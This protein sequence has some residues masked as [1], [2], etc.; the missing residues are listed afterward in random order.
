MALAATVDIQ[1][2]DA[3]TVRVLALTR[4]GALGASSRI[5]F[6]QYLP[7]LAAAGVQVEVQALFNDDM[8]TARY[9]RGGYGLGVALHCF[10]RRITALCTRGKFDLLWIEKEALPWWPLWAEL[11][12]LR[13]V[14]YALDYDD[15]VFHNYDQHRLTVVRHVLGQRL[16]GLMSRA[17][18]VV[19]G[20]DYLAQRARD[21]GAGWVEVLPTVI[22]LV[23]YPAPHQMQATLNTQLP[24]LVWIG[25]P[26]TVR[27]LHQL[28]ASL[29]ALAQRLPF[30][31]RVIGGEFSLPGVQVEC[32]PW[33]EDTEVADISAGDVGIMPLLDSSWERGKCGYKLIQYMACGLPVV[34]SPVGVNSSIVQEGVNGFLAEDTETWVKRLEQLLKNET[35]RMSMGA[36]GRLRVEQAYCVQATGP[37]LAAWL[38]TI[39]QKGE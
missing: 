34:A 37:Q 4:Y 11:T 7:A 5:R 12:L 3:V 23:R 18:L 30:V 32:L 28:Q 13:G 1:G 19:G 25:S 27:Y 38:R 35:L 14:P 39:A 20:N 31:L 21:A 26:S 17:A 24:I 2:G 10:G 16:D 8:L 29:Q 22:D 36:A 6:L 15:A 33:T 9:Q